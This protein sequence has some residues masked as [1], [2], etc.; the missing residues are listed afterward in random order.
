MP[1]VTVGSLND[2]NA[3]L[4]PRIAAISGLEA[5]FKLVFVPSLQIDYPFAHGSRT[6]VRV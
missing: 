6:I 3:I 5:V 2:S 4:Y 1:S